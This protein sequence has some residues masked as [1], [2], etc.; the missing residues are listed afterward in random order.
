MEAIYTVDPSDLIESVSKELQHVE[1]IKAPPWAAFCK[2]GSHAERPP[3]RPDW[4]YVRAASVMRKVLLKGP[5][6]VAKLKHLYGGKKNRG[7]KPEQF[8]EG[9]GNIARK[10]LQQLEKA[11]YLKQEAKGVHKGRVL[12]P[13]GKKVLTT[14]AEA[15]LKIK[16]KEVKYTPIQEAPKL[17]KKVEVKKEVV[18]DKKVEVKGAL[19][20]K[21]AVAPVA[22]KVK[23]KTEAV[24]EKKV[25]APTEKPAEVKEAPAKEEKKE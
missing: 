12:T 5:I 18:S 25:E 16:P 1:S 4:W 19:V 24:S 11:G 2:T 13:A 21:K 14:A 9:S 15:L 8:R 22:K 17:M 23:V 6:G 10:V 3:A 20:E 7:H